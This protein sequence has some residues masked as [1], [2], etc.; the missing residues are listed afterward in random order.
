MQPE[1][2]YKIHYKKE[3]FPSARE[4]D[5][6]AQEIE[7]NVAGDQIVTKLRIP[8]AKD[9]VAEDQSD[10]RVL[11]PLAVVGGLVRVSHQ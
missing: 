8:N 5:T 6:M 7:Q 1:T 3:A 4:A 10:F 9:D 11:L 2:G